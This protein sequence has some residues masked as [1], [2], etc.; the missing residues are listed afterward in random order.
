MIS[1]RLGRP[2]ALA[3]VL[4]SLTFALAAHTATAQIIPANR[5]Y[6]WNPGLISVGGIPNRTT[7]CATLSPSGGD[8]SPASEG[9]LDDIQAIRSAEFFWHGYTHDV[10]R[11]VAVQCKW[12]GAADRYTP[13]SAWLSCASHIG[14]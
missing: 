1:T 11:S 5:N 9:S 3:L 7:I 8:D 13:A 12:A 14:E 2:K 4:A 6:A 10:A